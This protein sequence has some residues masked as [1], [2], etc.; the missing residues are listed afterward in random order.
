M[1]FTPTYRPLADVLPEYGISRTRGF[2]LARLGLLDTF[3]IGRRRYVYIES[4]QTLH[5][6]I[7][8]YEG[9]KG[10]YIHHPKKDK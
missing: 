8:D 7:K 2:E 9:H 5:E 10:L 6:R 4:M 1:T 3:T